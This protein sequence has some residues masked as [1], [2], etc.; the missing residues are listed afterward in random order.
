MVQMV[1][2]GGAF[3]NNASPFPAISTIRSPPGEVLPLPETQTT[4][5]SLPGFNED[6]QPIY[7]HQFLCLVPASPLPAG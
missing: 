1:K 7:K 5:A 6:L 3:K 2:V 4:I